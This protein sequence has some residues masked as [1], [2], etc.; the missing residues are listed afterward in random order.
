MMWPSSSAPYPAAPPLRA[1]SG[2]P[3]S[4]TRKERIHATL[5][6]R[7]HGHV[8]CPQVRRL[9]LW[10]D[11]LDPLEVMATL[12][13][14][15][16]FSSPEEL[17]GAFDVPPGRLMATLLPESTQRLD[18]RCAPPREVLE[19]A[20]LLG[21]CTEHLYD[22]GRPVLWTRKSLWRGL[23]LYDPAGFYA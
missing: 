4:R 5:L 7:D 1:N 15:E 3:A 9:A 16:G 19:Q 20:L 6:G 2:G 23:E 8:R 21:L 17:R 12:L 13:A 22:P 14:R 11:L 10:F 18:V